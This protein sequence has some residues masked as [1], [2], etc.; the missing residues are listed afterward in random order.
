MPYWGK[1]QTIAEYRSPG[2]RSVFHPKVRDPICIA[3][4]SDGYYIFLNNGKLYFADGVIDLCQQVDGL[5]ESLGFSK[6][7]KQVRDAFTKYRIELELDMR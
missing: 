7:E 3:L 4:Y 5:L 6:D 2:S 1:T